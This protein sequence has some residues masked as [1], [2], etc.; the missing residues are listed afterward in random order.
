MC[1]YCGCRALTE[2]ADLT[3]QHEQIINATGPLRKAAAAQDHES[4]KT[5]VSSIV[6]LLNPHTS[7]EELGVFAELSKRT[8][9]TEHVKTLCAEHEHLHALFARMA[10][11]ETGLADTAINALRE[12]IEKEE[13]GLFPAAAVELEGSLWQELADRS[14]AVKRTNQS[15]IELLDL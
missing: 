14:G 3:A 12:H 8:E 11:G 4:I 10:N 2:I 13:N 6:A 7:Q 15:G 9:F 5:H 1:S